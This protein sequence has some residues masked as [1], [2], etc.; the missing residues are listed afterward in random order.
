MAS[1][2]KGT[3]PVLH[4]HAERIGVLHETLLLLTVTIDHVPTVPEKE[5]LQ[6]ESLVHGFY[7]IVAR[8]G[9]VETPD[10]PVLLAAAAKQLALEVD[11]NGITYYLGRE[12]FLATPKGKMGRVSES[13]FSFLSRYS[14]D[15]TSYF[16]IPTALV[17]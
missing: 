2:P 11:P 5:R 16:A 14:I 7:R 4:H 3:P 9:F 10:V 13:L 6:V 1:N 17:M 8:Y 12:T 15:A